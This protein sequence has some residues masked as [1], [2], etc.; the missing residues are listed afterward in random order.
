[1]RTKVYLLAAKQ[2]AVLRGHP[3]IFPK[4]IARTSG[5]LITGHLVD[6]YNEE[7]V[8]LG[9]GAYN[10]HSLYRVRV[11]ARANE[12]FATKNLGMQRPRDEQVFYLD[13]SVPDKAVVMTGGGSKSGFIERL[14]DPISSISEYFK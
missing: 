6:I 11:L 2:N 12:E 5:D 4:A 14:F 8:L 1:M 9:V 7:G 10:E 13:S 3:W